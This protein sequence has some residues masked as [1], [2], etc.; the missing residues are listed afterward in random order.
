MSR[1]RYFPDE[2]RAKSDVEICI[3]LETLVR[4][5]SIIYRDCYCDVMT[6]QIDVIYIDKN[7]HHI[8]I[9]TYMID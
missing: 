4:K 2:I 7:N 6:D 5:N 3:K 8:R 1:R 9:A